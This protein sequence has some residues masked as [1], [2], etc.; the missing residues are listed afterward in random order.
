[1]ILKTIVNFITIISSIFFKKIDNLNNSKPSNI[2]PIK[3]N[4]HSNKDIEVMPH[5]KEKYLFF[6]G[7]GVSPK[8]ILYNNRSMES[9][10]NT[11]KILTKDDIDIDIIPKKKNSLRIINQK[12][13]LIYWK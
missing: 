4:T 8:Q 13:S 9:R 3:N 2:T 1:M 11:E 10:V 12:K 5:L 6:K 7:E